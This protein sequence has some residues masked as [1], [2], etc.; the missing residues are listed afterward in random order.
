MIATFSTVYSS[1][2][3]TPDKIPNVWVATEGMAGT[4][5]QCIGVAEALGFPFKVHRISLRQPWKLLSPYLGFECSLS[6]APL[7]QPPWPDILIASGRKSIAISR[8]I[9]KQSQQKTF[10]VQ[11]QDPRISPDD[12]DLVAVPR[13]D[14]TRGDHILVTMATP[15]RVT[16]ARL[17]TAAKEWAPLFS[18]IPAPRVALLVGGSTKSHPFTA[19]ELDTL[20]GSLSVLPSNVTLL[21]TTSRRTGEENTAK[22]RDFC[23]GRHHYFWD[24]ELPNPYLGMLAWA[25]SILV[26]ADS[27][28]MI[29]EAA[30]TGKPVYTLPMMGLSRRQELLVENLTADGYIRPFA[31]KFDSWTPPRLADSA[32]IAQEI[33]KKLG[34]M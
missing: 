34:L 22:L 29:S 20:I 23:A 14:P 5:N 8:Y 10:T 16:L 17:E 6:F 26:T 28:S 11:I 4:E 30:S 32:L 9:K 31:G 33:R 24:G 13:H 25:D 1:P 19:Q 12:F 7:P 3:S 21:V 2:C 15:N 18:T 27:T